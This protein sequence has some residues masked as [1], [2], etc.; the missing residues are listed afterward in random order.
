ML[1][2]TS[3]EEVTSVRIL[4]NFVASGRTFLDTASCCAWFHAVGRPDL[5]LVACSPILKGVYDDA[6]KRAGYGAIGPRTR[7]PTP[8]L[9]LHC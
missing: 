8:R 6:A 7:D 3:T 2:V 4:D 5:R 9:G 1:M